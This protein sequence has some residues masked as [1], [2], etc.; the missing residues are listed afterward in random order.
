MIRPHHVPLLAA[1]LLLVAPPAAAQN[2]VD[3]E[4]QDECLDDQGHVELRVDSYGAFGSAT[5]VGDS[6][7]AGH[8]DPA[9]NEDGVDWPRQKTVFES[10][11]FLCVE[12]AGG[13]RPRGTWLEQGRRG[14]NPADFHLEDDV[15]TSE[16]EWRGVQ[17][18]LRAELVCNVLTECFR[19]TN[20][21]GGELGTVALTHYI[22]GDLFY[23][24]HH[25]NDY[26]GTEAGP[27]RT[28]YEFDSGDDPNAPTTYVGL[29]GSDPSDR[30]LTSWE[31]GEFM[32][33][34][35]RIAN[36]VGGC[37]VLRNDIQ[38]ENRGDADRDDDLITDSGFDVTIALRFDLGPLLP[39]ATSVEHCVDITWGVG[40][41]CGDPD[42][43]GICSNEDN[44]PF[45]F[46]PQQMDGDGDEVGDACDNCPRT[47]NLGQIDRDEDGIGDECDKYV[48][49]PSNDGLEICDRLDND[50]NGLV[51]DLDPS[52][53]RCPTGLPGVCASGTPTCQGGELICVVERV[54]GGREEVCNLLDDDC[55][56]TVDEDVRNA[57]GRCGPTPE[58]QCNGID[59]D[60]NGHIDEGRLCPEGFDCIDAICRV[61]CGG[62][63]GPDGCMDYEHCVDGYCGSLCYGF[64]CPP[65]QICSL[66]FEQPAS[67]VD[68][69]RDVE[70]PAGTLCDE[71]GRCGS[72]EAVGCPEGLTCAGGD[73]CVPDPCFRVYC[74]PDQVCVEGECQA[75]CATVTC[76][77]GQS[78][79]QGRCM[80]DPCGGITCPA[81]LT[82]ADDGECVNDE[83]V[84]TECE[85]GR[86]CRRGNCIGD[87]CIGV[88]CPET[89]VC[90]P[91]CVRGD[92]FGR[93]RPAWHG[94]GGVVDEP[95]PE[96]PAGDGDGPSAGGGGGQQGESPEAE[97][98]GDHGNDDDLQDPPGGV[99][100]DEPDEDGVGGRGEEDDIAA[101]PDPDS[102][103]GPHR[104]SSET[105]STSPGRGRP[106]SLAWCLLL[107]GWLWRRRAR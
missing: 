41:A 95:P 19:F 81:G 57:C 71:L 33:Q 26:G 79:R 23:V 30:L 13:R 73:R 36:V 47:L 87:P 37:T 51:D 101:T 104:R 72:C 17:A 70:C 7:H 106:P 22:D 25:D 53:A 10:M 107:A 63:D 96:E 62:G 8:F 16:W 32:E 90:V 58:E 15:L 4:S 98:G 75:S 80:A 92:C 35:E 99:A 2:W 69:C 66:D 14:D 86:I 46:N 43:D 91:V 38:R 42:E 9:P 85:P 49:R 27:P 100:D 56:G 45:V 44:C 97:P 77:M 21:T 83:C 64:E 40:Y 55:D 39:G 48:C 78:C 29:A 76:P 6:D 89:E 61:R 59:D 93:C 24:G 5:S 3:M 68:P 65:G 50:C 88:T 84:T 31:L 67:C 34:R 94:E 52:V 11:A 20:N 54:A 102:T 18:T 28:V 74:Q 12:D 60:C 105:C 103:D 1:A 82:C